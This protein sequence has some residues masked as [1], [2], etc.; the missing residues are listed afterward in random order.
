M[1]DLHAQHQTIDGYGAHMNADSSLA[2]ADLRAAYLNAGFNMVRL[3]VGPALYTN[4]KSG[5]LST[6]IPI[7]A[8]YAAN[9]ARFNFEHGGWSYLDDFIKHVKQNQENPEQFKL[10][11]SV[12]S[13]PHWLK[14]PTGTQINW[15]N[16]DGTPRSNY[17]PFFPYGA[18]GGNTGGGRVDPARYQ[19]MARWVLSF[20]KGYG[21]F[22][23]IPI[24]SFSFQ[25]EP[26]YEGFYNTTSYGRV[27]KD[28][29]NPSA[30]STTDWTLYA[31]A[32]QAI[33]DEL[34]LH[35]EIQ[36]KMI[37]PEIMTV[38]PWAN[39]NSD[40]V[41]QGLVDQ[42]LIDD[43]D[44]V[45]AHG[46]EGVAD[47]ASGWNT[48]WNRYDQDNRPIYMT[49]HSG[50][51]QNW[52]D[53]GTSVGNGALGLALK[54]HN[55]FTYGHASTFEYW[56]F[57][58]NTI[59]SSLVQ[60]A[61][62]STPTADYKYCAMIHFSK[63]IRPGAVRIGSSFENG[64]S[65]I[66]GANWLDADDS[67]NVSSYWHPV[68]KQLTSVLVNMR[69]VSDVTTIS[70][71]AG[72]N[73]ASVQQ[74]RTSGTEKFAQLAD[75][76]VVDG[77]VTL[78][79]P[80]YSVVTLQGTAGIRADWTAN[81][82]GS[83]AKTG[84]SRQAQGVWTVTGGG[85]DIWNNSDQFQFTSKT[86]TGNGFISARVDSVENTHY[87]AKAGVMMRAG[88][89]A[90]APFAMVVQMPNN[91]VSFQY[92]STA[93]GAV[94]LSGARLGGT[95]VA[96]FVKVTRVGSTFSGFYS[97][98]G[99]TW[100]QIGSAVTISGMPASIQSGLCVTSHDN[101]QLATATFSSVAMNDAPM[102][103]V[104][105]SAAPSPV[106]STQT[107]LSVVATDDA[108][109]ANLNYAWAT[110]GTPPAA[111]TFSQNN[112]NAAD[113]TTA[114]FTKAGIYTFRV[115]VTDSTT[116]SATSDVVVNVD[117]TP[118]TLT[119]NPSPTRLGLN[120]S[121][122]FTTL[123]MDQFGQAATA[124]PTWSLIGAGT[125]S[126]TGL[127]TPPA[128]VGSGTVTVTL[129]PLSQT[130]S[131]TTL[132][133][134][135]LMEAELSDLGGGTTTESSNIG[136]QGRSYINF[137]ANGGYAQFNNI[138]G[139]LGGSTTLS[140][141]FANG[142]TTPR[143]GRLRINGASQNI[144]FPVTGGWDNWTLVNVAVM[145]NPGKSN[146]IRLES[147]GQDLGNIDEIYL[148]NAVPVIAAAAAASP[149]PVTGT[150]ATL[151]VIGDDD[152]GE[153]KLTYTW[154]SVGTPPAAVTF[155]RN[156]SNLART[157]TAT[158]MKAGSYNF[159]V[160]VLDPLGV[161]TTANVALAVSQS[162]TRITTSPN[163][164]GV[165]QG[166][167]RQF[168]AAALD[169]FGEAMA[170]TFD[171]SATGG[172][173]SSAGL[174]TAGMT[175]GNYQVTAIVGSVIGSAAYTVWPA[176]PTSV[177]FQ[178]NDGSA[179]R[180]MIKSLTLAFDK[181][182]TLRT[183]AINLALR[184][185]T[186]SFATSI[187]NP[188]AD[189]RTYVLAFSGT[190]IVAGSLMDG[191][192]D[193]T[194]SASLV[195]DANGQTLSGGSRTY[196]F[197]RLFGDVTGNGTVDMADNRHMTIALGSTSGSNAYRW[198]LDYNGDGKIDMADNRQYIARMGR[199]V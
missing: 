22:V 48:F 3:E 186:T 179:Q 16:W 19:E 65:A 47:S 189:G 15:T 5:D 158:F 163:G 139:G 183:G 33:V 11:G 81:D 63:F 165:A 4:N 187:A 127:Y 8:D 100:T 104:P 61:N 74:F 30:G 154:T 155:S 113:S 123:V 92:R 23:G 135:S 198:Y 106:T 28:V 84:W 75:L 126:E 9:I 167:S 70:L 120:D 49:E 67:L 166:G 55:A 86:T 178:V 130:V 140:I 149:N 114:T 191:I 110:L 42:G 90:N 171:W 138:D 79:I 196:I 39:G 60:P 150:A 109:P 35:P 118:Q 143:I 34:A 85:N 68:D 58:N 156:G 1:L 152:L 153:S 99:A 40:Q 62:R 24:D 41:R 56:S 53:S 117:A 190:G 7:E 54:I 89:A 66:G 181:P 72:V 116:R 136:F 13:P 162:V 12:W 175:P 76:A 177:S 27:A 145:L 142:G 94:A 121:V 71:P 168:V 101:T 2:G 176:A 96:K 137:S 38:A 57:S 51:N 197:R 194:V 160:V 170:A 125:L 103:D 105:A 21:D 164:Q 112:S 144:T 108:G 31:D 128:A 80:A 134:R 77:K 36:T 119:L 88:T 32:F 25:N 172:T 111:V 169:Q 97:T 59:G 87:W 141:R 107:T 182:V 147:T 98:D 37:G 43:I 115:T 64:Q 133:Y 44:I 17:G 188:S 52:M 73:I 132:A 129:G 173:I 124:L 180:S 102:I 46:Y 146:I 122:Q 45:G 159:Q 69:P 174:L 199:S 20:V 184:T 131:M 93:G 95:A 192:F 148:A 14:I 83:P 157:T 161:S 50:E 10:S 151:S 185:G 18:S 195:V 6:S 26:D 29:N 78:T 193:L 82:V 91:E